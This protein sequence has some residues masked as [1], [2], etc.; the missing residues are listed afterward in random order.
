MNEC[1]MTKMTFLRLLAYHGRLGTGDET[2]MEQP[3]PS[4]GIQKRNK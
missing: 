2:K 1:E 4:S 3:N